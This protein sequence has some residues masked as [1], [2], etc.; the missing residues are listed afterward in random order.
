[1]LIYIRN[2]RDFFLIDKTTVILYGITVNPL[3]RIFS[4]VKILMKN[5]QNL[6]L[7]L[8]FWFSFLLFPQ[9]SLSPSSVLLQKKECRK[10][11]KKGKIKMNMARVC[12]F[13]VSLKINENDKR[14]KFHNNLLSFN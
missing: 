14:R 8:W 10:T 5:Y 1:M 4:Q 12:N 2:G 11:N 7:P 6:F 3:N 9:P 13:L